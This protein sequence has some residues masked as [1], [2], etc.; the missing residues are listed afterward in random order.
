MVDGAVE[1][2]GDCFLAAVGVVREPGAGG[3][4]EVVKHEKG[5]E[6]AEFGGADCASDSSTHAFGLFNR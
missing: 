2:V 5:G 1:E 3:A 4:G 6:V